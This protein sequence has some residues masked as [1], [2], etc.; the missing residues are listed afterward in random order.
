M[1]LLSRQMCEGCHLSD[2]TVTIRSVED[3]EIYNVLM[4]HRKVICQPA[5]RKNNLFLAKQFPIFKDLVSENLVLACDEGNVNSRTQCR[6]QSQKTEL[7]QTIRGRLGTQ[8]RNGTFSVPI[9]P[10]KY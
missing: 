3:R 5:K 10:G 2:H 4:A 8:N 6:D 7:N 9:Y 1:I